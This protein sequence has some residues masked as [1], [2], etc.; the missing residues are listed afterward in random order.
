M[1]ECVFSTIGVMDVDS[2]ETQNRN[3][4][5]KILLFCFCETIFDIFQ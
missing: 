5:M 3:I 4:E 2:N 1:K